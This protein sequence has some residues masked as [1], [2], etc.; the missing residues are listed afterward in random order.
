MATKIRKWGNSLGIRIPQ[1]L[2]KLLG[3]TEGSD[4]D[5]TVRDGELILT[6]RSAEIPTLDELV[7]G[8]TR[9]NRHDGIDTG[10]AVGR[11]AW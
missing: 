7:A 2:A 5:L 6:P 4:V 1:A 10:P 8:I 9:S 3:I 11:E